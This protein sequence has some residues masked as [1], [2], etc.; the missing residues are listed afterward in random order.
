MFNSSWSSNLLLLS[1]ESAGLGGGSGVAATPEGD[2]SPISS[3]LRPP[4]GIPS[5]R[6][7]LTSSGCLPK[8]ADHWWLGRRSPLEL[9]PSL[10]RPLH[11]AKT[12]LDA[13]HK[14]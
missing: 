5:S 8:P 3:T 7:A 9:L 12:A 1:V 11:L 14:M 13:S 4:A 6:G 2:P 10:Y